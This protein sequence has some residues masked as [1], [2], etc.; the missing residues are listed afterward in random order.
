MRTRTAVSQIM[1][2]AC[3]VRLLREA[4][5]ETVIARVSRSISA[6]HGRTSFCSG[7]GPLTTR[8]S[9][10]NSNANFQKNVLWVRRLLAPPSSLIFLVSCDFDQE[11][12]GFPRQLGTSFAQSEPPESCPGR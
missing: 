9:A 3:D 10:E 4:N 12:A 6:A 11:I 8:N 5:H 7:F 2:S 1:L